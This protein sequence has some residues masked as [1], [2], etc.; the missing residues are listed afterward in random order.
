[1]PEQK[2][3]ATPTRAR[4]SPPRARQRRGAR[5][6]GSPAAALLACR[7]D[8]ASNIVSA[9]GG[10]SSWNAAPKLPRDPRGRG[11]GS[12]LVGPELRALAEVAKDG[13]PR[14]RWSDRPGVAGALAAGFDRRVS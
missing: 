5:L 13:A 14:C 11:L 1:M 8:V 3:T 2:R 12:G 4:S 6:H 9:S 10:S 7:T